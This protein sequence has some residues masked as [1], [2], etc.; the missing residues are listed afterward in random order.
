MLTFRELALRKSKSR[1]CGCVRGEEPGAAAIPNPH[2]HTRQRDLL[3]SGKTGLIFGHIILLKMLA[4]SVV[5]RRK[6]TLR[7]VRKDRRI[8]YLLIQIVY[9]I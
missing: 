4:L 8:T 3:Y 5:N 2:T 7:Y 9:N 6:T 1:N